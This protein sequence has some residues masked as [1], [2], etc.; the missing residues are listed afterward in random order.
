MI[1]F[2]VFFITAS[3]VSNNHTRDSNFFKIYLLEILWLQGNF[4][5]KMNLKAHP[6][7]NV[8][9]QIQQLFTG[10]VSQKCVSAQPPLCKQPQAIAI[11]FPHWNATRPGFPHS[12]SSRKVGSLERDAS[13]H[14]LEEIRLKLFSKRLL[15]FPV[16]SVRQDLTHNRVCHICYRRTGSASGIKNKADVK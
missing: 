13:H 5:F 15:S 12:D 3:L 9:D 6:L 11:H 10:E 1:F 16:T 4:S 2:F 14:G 8:A 7:G